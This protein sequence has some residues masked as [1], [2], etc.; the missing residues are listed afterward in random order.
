LVNSFF[1]CEHYGK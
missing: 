1:S